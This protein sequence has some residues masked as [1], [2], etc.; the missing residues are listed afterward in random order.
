MAELRAT[1]RVKYNELPK[2]FATLDKRTNDAI[3][4][5]GKNRLIPAAQ[6]RQAPHIDT[7]ALN[8]S[9]EIR[10]QGF[11]SI[12]I[13]FTGGAPGRVDGLPRIYAAYH[14][15]GTRFTGAYPFLGPAVDDTW[16]DGI[17]QDIVAIF[18]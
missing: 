14:E 12:L 13:V 18:Q 6:R 8:A 10:G 2:I 1:V 9:G 5:Y 3:T 11:L 15:Y 4:N 7:G 17:F 16:P